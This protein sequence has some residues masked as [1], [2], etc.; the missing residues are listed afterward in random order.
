MTAILIAVPVHGHG[1]VPW[2]A[3]LIVCVTVFVAAAAIAYVG[4]RW[5]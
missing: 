1:S 2:W 4:T 5:R 3:W